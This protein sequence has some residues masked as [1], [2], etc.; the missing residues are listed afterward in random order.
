[1]LPKI[2]NAKG[3]LVG[4]LTIPGEW[5][6]AHLENATLWPVTAQKATYRGYDIW[7]LPIAEELLPAVAIRRPAGLSPEGCERLLLRFL[8]ALAWSERT[9]LLVQGLGGGGLPRQMM[10]SVRHRG[11]ICEQF[12]LSYLPEP[13]DDKA[14]LALALMREGRG[15]N[16][17]GYSFLSFYRVLEVALGKGRRRQIDWIN[18][19]IAKG[20]GHSSRDAIGGLRQRGITDIGEHLY[21][22][23]RCAMAHAAEEPIIDP[24]DPTDTRR[25]W[26]ERPIVLELAE[27][28]IEGKLGVETT[29]TVYDKHLY[30]LDGF[31]RILG[32]EIVGHLVRGDNP[33]AGTMVDIPNIGVRI[34][35]REPYVPLSNLIIKEMTRSGP[36]A[37]RLVY[38]LADDLIVFRVTLDFA[39]ERLHF[40]LFTDIGYRDDG[41][42]ASAEIIAEA[43][44]FQADLFG[45][46]QLQIVNAD[47]GELISRKDAYLPVNM[48]ANP[49]GS[50]AL[51]TRW[52]WLAHKRRTLGSLF[53][54]E[55]GR[56]SRGYKMAI[57][58]T[59]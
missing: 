55:M 8:S 20:L 49:E 2:K 58:A 4:E 32:D 7:I 50:D 47:T 59:D 53:A 5:I 10:D 21:E 24:D 43:L 15:L 52:K 26:T 30:E 36:H 48:F 41:T 25:L 29:F 3:V 40:S 6:V 37:L 19:E 57:V 13:T 23:G 17:P 38:N 45:N 34:R 14:L 35:H 54:E 9:G 51:I 1:M 44:R 16:H 33:P 22:S 42:A 31:K 12:D 28:A 18:D 27:R 11:A 39:E 46:G 56:W